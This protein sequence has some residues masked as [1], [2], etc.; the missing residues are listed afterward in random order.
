MQTK[1][2]RHYMLQQKS[3]SLQRDIKE[4]VANPPSQLWE[5]C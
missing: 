3:V 2:L 4:K 1:Y 5:I